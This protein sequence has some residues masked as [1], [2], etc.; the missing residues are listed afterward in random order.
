MERDKIKGLYFPYA[1][2]ESMKTL[3]T[4]VLYFDKVGV[5]MPHAGFCSELSDYRHIRDDRHYYFRETD[6]L[7]REGIMEF[8]DPVSVIVKFGQQIM[9]GVIQDLYDEQ[10]HE[11]CRPFA[12]TPWVLESAKLPRDADKWL[13]NM[14]VNVPTLAREG[15]LL[16]EKIKERYF[17]ESALVDPFMRKQL[18]RFEERSRSRYEEEH[19]SQLL[20]QMMFDEYR[21]VELPF[22]I[23][24]SI[25]IGH[26]LA[27]AAEGTFTPFCD[28]Q[29]HLDV[30]R[31]KVKN[32]DSSNPLRTVLYEYGYL[33]D[34][35]V[36]MLAHDVIAETIPSLECVP[37]EVILKF[38]EKRAE[39]LA[40]FRIEMRKLIIEIEQSPWDSSF[41][42]Y[43]SNVVDSKVKPALKR[44]ENEIRGCKD[45]FWAD[46]IK[47]IAKVSPL[48]IV[49]SVFVG[50]PAHVALGLGATLA[51]LT[52]A[53]EQWAKVRKVKRNGWAFLLDAGRLGLRPGSG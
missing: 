37:F 22:E 41:S 52:L 2:I 23:G 10:Y 43:V 46:A 8:V 3:K 28:E 29:I 16:T 19:K 34:A 38:R 12:Q 40:N 33:K 30:L 11:V 18:G 9:M 25:M 32:F 42:E 53:L 35:K 50:V 49:G 17:R 20:R 27:V 48:P 4:A 14:L 31:T 45:A 6:V 24:E 15:S 7:V 13:R 1:N 51:S 26:T 47:T 36:D 5:I 39:E 21:L 44:V